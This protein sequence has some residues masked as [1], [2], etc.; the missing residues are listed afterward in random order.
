[1]TV[2]REDGPAIVQYNEKGE[3]IGLE[4]YLNGYRLNEKDMI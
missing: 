1:M 4:Y 3:P 2:H